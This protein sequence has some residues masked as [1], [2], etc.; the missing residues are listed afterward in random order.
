MLDQAIQNQPARYPRRLPV[1]S[2]RQRRGSAGSRK[3]RSDD[4][5]GR[6][7][8]PA[9]PLRIGQV[10]AAAHHRRTDRAVL[11]RRQMPRRDHRGPAERRLHGVS[12]VR[13]VSLADGA[14]ER[15]TRPGG[16]RRRERRA[17]HA[18]AGRDRPDRPRRISSPPIR[19]NCRAACASASALPARWWCIRTCC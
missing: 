4:P 3:S 7:R 12:V 16:A 17:P 6:N 9:R 18:R 1:V 10:D 14:A 15:R 2:E 19:R 5:F 13:A 11:G 8:R